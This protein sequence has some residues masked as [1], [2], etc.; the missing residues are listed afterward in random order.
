MN[1][2]V[3]KAIEV[4]NQAMTTTHGRKLTDVEIL[5][6][7]GAWQR[8]SYDQVAA[9]NQYSTSYISQDIAPRLWKLLSEATGEK[10]KKNS[11][12]EPLKRYWEASLESALSATADPKTVVS[13]DSSLMSFAAES[14][15][16]LPYSTYIHHFDIEELCLETL[17]HH[18]GTLIRIKSPK[19]TGKTSLISF[20]V[21]QLSSL[22]IDSI[23]LSLDMA[24]H[25]RHFSDIDIFLRW[26]CFCLEQEL[27]LSS[28][29]EQYWSAEFVGSKV[30]CTT[31]FEKYILQQ[32]AAPLVLCIDDVDVLFA[33]PDL[34]E[35]FFGLLRSWHEKARSRGIWKKLHLILSHSTEAYIRL[36]INQ[37]PFNIGLLIELPD[38]E[39][40]QAA[41]LAQRAGLSYRS[42]EIEPILS[43]L[44]GHPYLL[45]LAFDHLKLV[46]GSTIADFLRNAPTQSGIYRS[47]LQ[48][49]W[50]ELKERPDLESAFASV[51]E[52]DCPVAL[53]PT[54]AYQL[55]SMGLIKL[56]G[57]LAKVSCSLYQQYFQANIQSLNPG[58]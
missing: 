49:L 3:D 23:N 10:I 56:T 6:L 20:L 41:Q 55:Q 44:G 40:R 42:K 54:L 33:Y 46:P 28:Q 5:V 53:E 22:G 30:S 47:H 11:L 12:R 9:R 31:Y 15:A 27:N 4:A 14:E 36:N 34:C 43:L 17:I 24:D 18:T 21:G 39:I 52:A 19:L 58:D 7:T 37:S 25:Q 1:F 51:I 50:Q 32:N 45:Q 8:D 26:F 57:N 48:Q 35:D 13:A 2:N 29:L 16:N 38:F